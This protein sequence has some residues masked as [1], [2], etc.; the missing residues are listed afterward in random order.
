[1][2]KMKYLLSLFL[3][4]LKGKEKISINTLFRYVYIYY[5]SNTYLT[6]NKEITDTIAIDKNLGIGNYSLLNEALQDLNRTEYVTII[7]NINISVTDKLHKFID[8]LLAQERAKQDLNRILYFTEILSS[9]SEDVILSVF[10]NEPN[11]LDAVGRNQK[12]I[13]LNNN[14]LKQLLMKFEKIANEEYNNKLD[15]YDVFVSW[16]DYVF[17]DYVRGKDIDEK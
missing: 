3:Y 8:D 5:V 15:K 2:E 9:Y 10:F 16:L 4:A 7:D 13:Y 6:G 1:M 14:K 12:V 11:F 17:E